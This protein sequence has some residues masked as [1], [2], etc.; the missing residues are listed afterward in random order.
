VSSP[1]ELVASWAEQI[2]QPL[3]NL[4]I[5]PDRLAQLLSPLCLLYSRRA[6]S[7]RLQS[8]FSGM[9]LSVLL[10]DCVPSS[11]SLSTIGKS[12]P[13]EGGADGQ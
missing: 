13:T 8:N 9:G 5:P 3:R 11:T 12:T 1:E 6:L 10:L 2:E 4:I 7:R